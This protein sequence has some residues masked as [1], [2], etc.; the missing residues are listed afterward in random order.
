MFSPATLSA[1]RVRLSTYVDC[2]P[3]LSWILPACGHAAASCFSNPRLPLLQLVGGL[4]VPPYPPSLT[5][6]HLRVSR[7]CCCLCRPLGLFL[8][9]SGM[10]FPCTCALFPRRGIAPLFVP[11]WT[12]VSRGRHSL[13]ELS[14]PLSFEPVGPY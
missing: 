12:S 5:V 2:P 4:S 14:V 13:R 1:D 3:G 10:Y 9:P 7:V 8:Y 11:L 6:T